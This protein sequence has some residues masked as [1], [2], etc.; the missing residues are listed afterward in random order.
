MQNLPRIPEKK[1]KVRLFKSW[2]LPR[3]FYRT[4]SRE[5]LLT[6]WESMTK[7]WWSKVELLWLLLLCTIPTR[8]VLMKFYNILA[9]DLILETATKLVEEFGLIK[10]NFFGKKEKSND[11]LRLWRLD[12][13]AWETNIWKSSMLSKIRTLRVWGHMILKVGIF[14]MSGTDQKGARPKKLTNERRMAPDSHYEEFGY[15]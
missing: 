10:I 11:Q 3:R 2:L 7:N 6:K 4:S 1:I 8:I 9:K 13:W 5:V 12:T 15:H 14:W